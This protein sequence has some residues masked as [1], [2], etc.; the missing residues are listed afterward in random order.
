MTTSASPVESIMLT[1]NDSLL[2]N[3]SDGGGD[4]C[5]GAG[6]YSDGSCRT[7]WPFWVE[8]AV[9]LCCVILFLLTLLIVY[10]R[11]FGNTSENDFTKLQRLNSDETAERTENNQGVVYKQTTDKT[12]SDTKV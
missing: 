12:P 8:V 5:A 9:P 6:T 2:A 10:L 4:V 7:V 11:P 3:T 1:L